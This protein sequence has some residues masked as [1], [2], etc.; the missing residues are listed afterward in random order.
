MH[1][2]WPPSW[3]PRFPDVRRTGK[4]GIS[5]CTGDAQITSDVRALF[6]QHPELEPPNLLYVQTLD[7]VVYLRGV[8]DTDLERQMAESVALQAKGCV[9][10]RQLDRSE[11]RPLDEAPRIAA[12]PGFSIRLGDG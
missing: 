9:T 2:F 5:G 10:R 1:W 4:C 6:S 7:H 3:R 11:R 12:Q 8:V